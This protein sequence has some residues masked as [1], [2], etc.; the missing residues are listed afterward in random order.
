MIMN[1]ESNLGPL[2][3]QSEV[4]TTIPKMQSALTTSVKNYVVSEETSLSTDITL[5]LMGVFDVHM[6]SY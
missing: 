6:L 2:G 4:L 3:W 1:W 5:S